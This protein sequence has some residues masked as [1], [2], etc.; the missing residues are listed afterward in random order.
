MMDSNSET[1]FFVAAASIFISC[2]IAVY[3]F[4][5]SRRQR[6]ALRE[7]LEKNA[8]MEKTLSTCREQLRAISLKNED[9]ARLTSWL[10]TRVRDRKAGA[11]KVNSETSFTAQ[12]DLLK[13]SIT[14]RRHRVLKLAARGQ[15]P[16]SIAASLGMFNGEVELILNLNRAI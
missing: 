1:L 3:C 8:E 10:E 13:S 11:E 5:Q 4:V 9:L 2:A 12:A 6:A 14:E 15:N 7:C 16:E